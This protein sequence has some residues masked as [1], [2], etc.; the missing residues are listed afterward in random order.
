MEFFYQY[1]YAKSESFS[2]IFNQFKVVHV[3]NVP[4]E[5]RDEVFRKLALSAGY[6]LIY[7]EDPI[8]GKLVSGKWTEIK[9]DEAK[10]GSSYKYSNSFQPLHTDYGYFA[11]EIYASFFFCE[12][13]AHFGGATT[14]IDLDLIV[15]ILEDLNPQLLIDLQEI[16][17]RNGRGNDS[18]SQNT[19]K[20]LYKKEG[21]WNINWNFY[22]IHPTEQSLP[23][24]QDFKHF[25]D[26]FIEKSGELKEVKLKV[27]EG[28]F[29]HDRRILH[30][31]NSFIGNRHLNKGGISK[32]DPAPYIAAIK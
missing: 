18:I 6:P 30:G 8:S 5:S 32:V 15:K 16:T 26:H 25:L 7:D 1:D 9:F 14:F 31:R 2:E 12:A 3:I 4:N 17:I 24:I 29:F 27:G 10:N 11:M 19:S 13:Q 23:V 20:I 22:R 21:E 28:V